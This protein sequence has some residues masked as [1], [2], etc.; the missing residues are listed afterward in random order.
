[1]PA[2]YWVELPEIVQLCGGRPSPWPA[3]PEQLQAHPAAL[4]ARDHA[5]HR[6]HPQFALQPDGRGLQP[7]GTAGLAE[8][9]LAHRALVLSIDIYEHLIFDGTGSSPSPRWSRACANAMLT[10]NENTRLCR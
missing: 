8:V 10:M 6:N 5:A 3:M 2:P 1:M 7:R 4:Q 9:L